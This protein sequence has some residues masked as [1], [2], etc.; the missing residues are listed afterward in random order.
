MTI[1]IICIFLIAYLAIV[2]EHPLKTD[3]AASALFA[4]AL[5]WGLIISNDPDRISSLE[6][7]LIEIS[8]IVFFLIGAMTIV[9]I[10]D[11]R[12]GFKILGNL[13]AA[14]TSKG[15]VLPISILTFFLSAVLDNLTTAIVMSSIIIRLVPNNR[16][17]LLLASLVIII[18]NAGGAWS[19][20]GDI[21]TTMLWVGGQITTGTVMSEVFLPS[22]AA[23][24]IPA[25]MIY[26]MLDS[27][28]I[29]KNHE[30]TSSRKGAFI[31]II[32]V[33]LL[34]MVPIAKIVFH[35]P[36]WLAMLMALG[37]LW[38]ISESRTDESPTSNAKITQI[39]RQI[40]LSSALFF[41]GILLCVGA[42]KEIGLLSTLSRQILATINSER[43]IALVIGALSAVID[44]V[45]LVAASMQTFDPN[46]FHQDHAFWTYLSYC[47]GTGGSMLVIGSAAGIAAMGVAKIQFAWYF[48]NITFVALC[49]YLAGFVTLLL[50]DI[51]F[52]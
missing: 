27:Q 23:A 16:S 6:H 48:R 47:A 20:I 41:L 26:K 43:L 12:G 31:L 10:I 52:K 44:N 49:G 30:S 5:C 15:L 13:L 25:L 4:G 51:L 7:H 29:Q 3:K 22:V 45:P 42:L 35:L 28:E 8:G 37:V 34:C 46:Q 18:A 11:H 36:P 39:L 1:M 2:L 38:L 40:D 19:P 50:Q 9:E 33:F 32:G 14:R 24:L 21:T 17:K